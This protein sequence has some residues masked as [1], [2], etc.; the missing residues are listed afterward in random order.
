M[1]IIR[2]EQKNLVDIKRMYIEIVNNMIDMGISIWNEYY[3]VEMF[4]EDIRK[5]NLYLLKNHDIIVGAFA[6]YEHKDIE[7]DVKWKDSKAPAFLLNR[8]GV[9]VNYLR[10]GIGQK[11][12]EEASILAKEKGAKYL[13]LLVVE[14]NIPAIKLYEKCGFKRVEGIHEE[15]IS[16]DYYHLEYAYEK[17]L[18][19][20]DVYYN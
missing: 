9:N 12:V 3:P 7:S 5:K 6:I 13:R 10:Q 16:D 15:K 20:S 17:E 2:A 1:K 11:L 18:N 8:V 19:E 14:E 4:E